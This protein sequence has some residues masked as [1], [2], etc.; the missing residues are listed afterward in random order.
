MRQRQPLLTRH[1]L[2][3]A[4]VD[5]GEECRSGL[6]APGR[7]DQQGVLALGDAR[8][9]FALDLGRST[10]GREKPILSRLTE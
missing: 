7:C 3:H 6:T 5:T 8:P 10:K 4:D 1:G 9:P 2:A